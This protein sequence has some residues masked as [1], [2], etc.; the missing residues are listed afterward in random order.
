MALVLEKRIQGKTNSH[1][2]LLNL[3]EKQQPQI[4]GELK[5][6]KSSSLNIMSAGSVKL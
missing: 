5:L 1:V 6:R 2:V 4:S 3:K